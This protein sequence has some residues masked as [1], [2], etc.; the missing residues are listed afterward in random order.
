MLEWVVLAGSENASPGSQP[1]MHREGRMANVPAASERRTFNPPTSVP[2]R[3]WERT[4][5]VFA[6]IVILVLGGIAGLRSLM[7]LAQ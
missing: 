5:F 6:L 3:N 1:M 4:A 2:I 7:S